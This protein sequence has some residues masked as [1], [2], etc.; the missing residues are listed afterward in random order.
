[1]ISAIPTALDIQS[2]AEIILF[3]TACGA[4]VGLEREI[5]NKPAGMKTNITICV[6]AALFTVTSILLAKGHQPSD[7]NRVIAQIVSGI[8]FL[9]A[10]AIFKSGDNITGLTTASYIWLMG[11]IGVLVGIGYGPMALGIT[12]GFMIMSY[13]VGKFET[14][15]VRKYARKRGKGRKWKN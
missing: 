15:Y 1:M 13:L 2:Y 4:M 12:L 5:K 10:G 14:K 7:I 6:G 8:G 11:A 9:G 3:A